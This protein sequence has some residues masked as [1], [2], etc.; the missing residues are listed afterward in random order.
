MQSDTTVSTRITKAEIIGHAV[1]AFGWAMAMAS[2]SDER[3]DDYRRAQ[4]LMAAIA[5]RLLAISMIVGLLIGGQWLVASANAATP[6]GTILS[7]QPMPGA[8]DQAKSWRILYSST[9]LSGEPI[10]VSGV[11]IV[12]TTPPPLGGRPIVAWAHPTTGIVSRCA[13]SLARVFFASVQGLR[14]MLARGYVVTATDYPGLGTPETHPYLVG[15]SEGRAVLDSVRAA[16]Q[17]VAADAGSRFAVWGHSQGGQASL[18]TG[19]LAQQYAPELQ[20]VGVAAAAPAT[21]LGLLMH[22]DLGT[23]GGNNITAMTLW[24][25][26]RVYGAPMD[27]VVTPQARLVI[28]GLARLCIERWFDVLARRGPTRA[29]EKSFLRINDPSD[30]EPWRGLLAENS[31]GPLPPSIPVFISQ[32]TADALVHPAITAAYVHSLCQQNSQVRFALVQNVGHAF[33]ARD[34][35][36]EAVAWI[37]SRFNGLTPPNDCSKL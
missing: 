7:A 35:A 12:P 11:V 3:D 1:T 31:P 23:G 2:T 16:R 22:D 26:S 34:T 32:G 13:P 5:W 33:I 28:D 15:T 10:T 19:L 30:V 21:D 18:Y 14:D 37:A 27:T 9:G 36:R 6:P 17:V 29:L 24:S 20:L 4:W 25:W 8:P